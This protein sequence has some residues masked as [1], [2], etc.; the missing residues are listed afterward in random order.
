MNNYIL[1]MQ[2]IRKTFLDG[3]VIAN[4]DITLKILQG[5]KHGIV[6]ENGAGNS[7]LMK[8]LYVL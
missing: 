7:T 1:E 8:R 4:D 2:H 5:E 3:K 6:S